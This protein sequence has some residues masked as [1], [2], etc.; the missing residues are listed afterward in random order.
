MDQDKDQDSQE[1]FQWKTKSSSPYREEFFHH[2]LVDYCD[3]TLPGEENREILRWLNGNPEFQMKLDFIRS[4]RTDLKKLNGIEF[5]EKVVSDITQSRSYLPFVIERLK[6]RQW[7]PLF[8]WASEA[9]LVVFV[10]VIIL[11]AIPWEDS[12]KKWLI[13]SPQSIILAEFEKEPT[14]NEP[15]SDPQFQ[16]ELEKPGVASILSVP[17]SGPPP[18]I[19]GVRQLQPLAPGDTLTATL[20][21]STKVSMGTV[22]TT[23][24]LAGNP[25]PAEPAKLPMV[26]T[27][28]SKPNGATGAPPATPPAAPTPPADQTLP[29][30]P[31]TAASVSAIETEEK[32]GGFLYRGQVNVTNLESVWPKIRDRIQDIGGRKAGEVE[33]G[34]RKSDTLRYFHFT[35]PEAQYAVLKKFISQYGELQISKEKHGRIMP[36]GIIRIIL[37]VNEGRSLTP[38]SSSKPPPANEPS[39]GPDSPPASEPAE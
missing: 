39:A 15:V 19:A 37:N 11:V 30:P 38:D 35:V 33:L 25:K 5:S 22:P 10:M 12:V 24:S 21:D 14:P 6:V 16:D 4:L 18:S 20:L 1:P 31:T 9:L 17:K 26:G 23:T 28:P 32:S 7:P 3:N 29:A 27:A 36:D 8:R 13:K 34:W 2:K